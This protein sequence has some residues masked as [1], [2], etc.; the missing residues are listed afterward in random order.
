MK[1]NQTEMIQRELE[2]LEAIIDGL[3]TNPIPWAAVIKMIAPFLIRMAI[4]AVLRKTK[5]SLAEDKVNTLARGISGLVGGI[6]DRK[7]TGVSPE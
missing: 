1:S 5:R 2:G 6:I 3:P 7:F 4:R